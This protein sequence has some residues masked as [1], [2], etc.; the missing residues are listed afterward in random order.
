[1]GEVAMS[2]YDMNKQVVA[3]HC[4]PLTSKQLDY[5]LAGIGIWF[6]W[7]KNKYF[8]LLC[9]EER[10]YTL[11][12]FSNGKRKYYEATRELLETLQN[13]GTVL[14]ISYEQKEEAYS[15]WIDK[16]GEPFLYHLFPYDV[17]VIEV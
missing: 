9:H 14:E 15:F 12:H 6:S 16:E 2:L 3:Q 10:D 17:G 1:M 8:M 4:E 7:T 11:I 5:E 13:R